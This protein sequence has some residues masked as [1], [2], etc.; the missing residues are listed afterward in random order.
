M[1]CQETRD[2][3]AKA[4]ADNVRY[5]EPQ[6]ELADSPGAVADLE[7]AANA[8][9]AHYLQERRDRLVHEITECSEYPNVFWTHGYFRECRGACVL[10]T[11]EAVAELK[12]ELRRERLRCARRHWSAKPGRLPGL[13]EALVFARYFR[14]F[15][16]KVWMREAA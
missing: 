5:W 15:G 2:Y 3:S 1:P 9:Q 13:K 10:S 16:R 12:S 14:W 7:S 4:I 8:A 11:D 6:P